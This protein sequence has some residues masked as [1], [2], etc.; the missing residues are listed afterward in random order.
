MEK[1]EIKDNEEINK[2]KGLYFPLLD[3]N[4]EEVVNKLKKYFILYIL[5]LTIK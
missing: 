3:L 4:E 5:Y 1:Q 2:K